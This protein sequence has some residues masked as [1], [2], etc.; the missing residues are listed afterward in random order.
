MG[1]SVLVD[2]SYWLALELARDQYHQVAISHW[3]SVALLSSPLTLVTTSFIFAEVVAYMSNHGFHRK[4]VQ[5]GNNL[6]Q[7][8]FVQFIHVD[9]RLLLDA[10]SYFQRHDDKDYSLADCV[11]FVVM[12]NLNITTAFAFDRHFEQAGYTRQP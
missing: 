2:T 6:M 1:N 9:A 4:A 7:D 5:F 12:R 3:Q 10:W 8:P 11:S